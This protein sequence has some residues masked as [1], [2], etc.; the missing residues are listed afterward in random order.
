[1]YGASS[2]EVIQVENAWYA[3][4]IG[5][6]GGGGGGCNT[7]TGLSAS[8][9]TNTTA[10]V[11]WGAVTGA[12]SYNLQYK[13]SASQTWTTVSGLT[14]T[15][16]NLTNLTAGTT[17]NY[18]VQTVCS[19][20]TS[21]YT[22]SS[23][24]TTG[25]SITYC[26]TSGNT[27]YEYINKVVLGT[28]NNTSGNNN[29]Y[30]DYTGLSTNLAAGAS[31]SITV[32]P[33]FTGSSYTEVW[34]VFID[35]NHN[36]TLNDAGE[37][38]TVGSGA[39]SVTKSFT[40]PSTAKSGATR[41]RVVMHYSSARTNPCGTFT[42]GEA[43]DYT[44]NIT[45]GTF[46]GIASANKSS[47][48]SIAVSPNPVKASV[49]NIVLQT[50]K[51]APVNIKITDLTGRILRAETISN[52]TVGKNNYAL[53]NLSLLPG[54]YMIVAEQGNMIIARNQFIVAR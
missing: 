3:V 8:S 14:T 52:I 44:V 18:Q 40:V 11:N 41:M 6:A 50:I 36:G 34:R 30:G 20:G 35:Y 17:Y 25:G 32:T 46:A 2:N 39:G 19:A 13:T 33:G 24:A 54:T 28:I 43:E 45:G 7:P 48:N 49:A 10:T 31:A 12:V 15:S 23:F 42:D 16:Y 27:T 1:L 53:S 21:S 51:A 5:T 9:I 26:T 29:G 37:M 38:I 4:G 47:A 22:A